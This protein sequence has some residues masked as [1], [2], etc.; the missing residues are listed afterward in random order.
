[1]Q[2]IATSDEAN[3][4]FLIS[5]ALGIFFLLW[6]LGA[7]FRR[8]SVKRDLYERGCQP[9]HIWWTVWAF[10]A[11]Y[12]DSI[13]FR[14][15]YVDPFGAVHKARCYVTHDLFGSAFGPRTVRWVK[16]EI[17]SQP[18]SPEVWVDGEIIRPKLHARDSSTRDAG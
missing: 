2:I 14:V 18:I 12:L 1:M 15:I 11:P 5:I 3:A 4:Y 7:M 9:K 16:D 17:T 13:P 6:F 8:E 10:W